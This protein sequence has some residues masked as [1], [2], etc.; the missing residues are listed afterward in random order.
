[1]LYPIV[2]TL[3][4]RIAAARK[5]LDP[6][7]TQGELGRRFKISDKAVSSWERD[8]SVPEVDKL[9]RIARELKVPVVWLLEGKLPPPDVTDPAVQIE[10][11]SEA[12]QRA[13][14]AF[15]THLQQQKAKVA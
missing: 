10:A 7:V 4:K 5:R 2:M 6:K 8:E 3:G 11:L 15:I 13:V 14:S 12:D 1:M 9:P